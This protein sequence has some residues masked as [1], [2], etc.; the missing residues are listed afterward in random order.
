MFVFGLI[1]IVVG[2]AILIGSDTAATEMPRPRGSFS[3]AGKWIASILIV[4][5]GCYLT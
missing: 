1:L 5:I 2:V 3:G 4:A